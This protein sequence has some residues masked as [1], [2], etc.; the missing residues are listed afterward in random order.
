[1]PD[2]QLLS[3]PLPVVQEIQGFLNFLIDSLDD[4]AEDV[5]KLL[6]VCALFFAVTRLFVGR[7]TSVGGGPRFVR[8]AIVA[9]LLLLSYPTVDKI[10]DSLGDKMNVVQNQIRVALGHRP[11]KLR[12]V[13]DNVAGQGLVSQ[14]LDD[15]VEDV[16]KFGCIGS[17]VVVGR[18]LQSAVIVDAGRGTMPWVRTARTAVGIVVGVGTPAKQYSSCDTYAD[19][20]GDWAQRKWSRWQ[21]KGTA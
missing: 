11:K 15:L 5:A 21:S 4:V 1:M 16:F 14:I 17:H 19:Q 3:A 12:A 10:S 6:L 9:V 2:L 13:P 7:L 8:L 20:L 18:M